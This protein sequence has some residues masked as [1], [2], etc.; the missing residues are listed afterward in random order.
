MNIFRIAPWY[1]KLMLLLL[2]LHFALRFTVVSPE[3]LKLF[4]PALRDHLSPFGLTIDFAGLV[5][6]GVAAW[7]IWH[8]RPASRWAIAAALLFSFGYNLFSA[9]YLPRISADAADEASFAFQFGNL[10]LNIV[11]F[12]WAYLCVFG[13]RA[14][15]FF[16]V[17]SASGS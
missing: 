16:R 17:G 5:V 14:L 12:C 4:N 9:L 7:A 3:V 6:A 1:L 10:S 11:I 13:E 2:P 8:P 15:D